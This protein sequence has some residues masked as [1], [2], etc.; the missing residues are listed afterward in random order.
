MSS[1]TSPILNPD[2]LPYIVVLS[3]VLQYHSAIHSTAT[4]PRY[5]EPPSTSGNILHP[6]NAIL[7]IPYHILCKSSLLLSAYIIWY[8]FTS[9]PYFYKP[10][11][12]TS[13]RAEGCLWTP[14]WHHLY[15]RL[16]YLRPSAITQTAFG[17]GV[18]V[19]HKCWHCQCGALR[20]Y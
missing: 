20:A 12:S 6:P 4:I 11:N 14:A 8:L 3:A 1:L 10:L 13:A 19:L 16:L 5:N 9:S 2:T 18:K 17:T 7:L 15:L